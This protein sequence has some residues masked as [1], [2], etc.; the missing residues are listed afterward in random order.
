[1]DL[2]SNLIDMII[3]AYNPL[4]ANSFESDQL[5]GCHPERKFGSQ[6]LIICNCYKI[7]SRNPK[8]PPLHN[9]QPLLVNKGNLLNSTNLTRIPAN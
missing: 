7:E 2:P 8:L 6:D 3:Q 9:L 4:K 5:A 1:M